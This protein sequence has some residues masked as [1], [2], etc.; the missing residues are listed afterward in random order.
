MNVKFI[1]FSKE[2]DNIA[3]AG[4]RP[5]IVAAAVAM[6]VASRLAIPSSELLDPSTYY[7][8]QANQL[9]SSELSRFNE[10]VIM[11]L[12]YAIDKCRMFWMLRYQAAYP[13]K[14]IRYGEFSTIGFYDTLLGC[15][16][17]SDQE[18]SCFMNEYKQEIFHLANL[19][20]QLI[21]MPAGGDVS[22]FKAATQEVS[23]SGVVDNSQANFT[24]NAGYNGD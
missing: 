7:N 22:Y 21:D 13:A 2:L 1:G 9:A 5:R 20:N 12:S 16:L 23:V 8:L 18:T 15:A 24:Q 17:H 10:E 4:T 19:A 11:D 6:A 3:T 14:Q